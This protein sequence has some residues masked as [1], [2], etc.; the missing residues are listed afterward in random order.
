LAKLVRGLLILTAFLPLPAADWPHWRGPQRNDTSTEES[1]WK[2]GM[3]WLPRDVA[4]SVNVGEGSTSPVVVQGRL[5]TLGWRD[6][7]D[8]VVCLDA[9]TGKRQWRVSYKAPR[10]G[11][12]ATGDEGLYSGVTA[13]P[14]YDASTGL[15]YTLGVDGDL[16]CWDTARSG[17]RVWSLNLYEKYGVRQRPRI[18]R[19]GL[20]DY[21]YTTA[22][23]IQ[24]DLLIVEVGADEG[25]LMAF[26]KRSGQ[27][28]WVSQSK[29]QAGHTG[30]PVPM[31]VEGKPC[32]AVLTLRHLLVV[33]IDGEQAGRTVAEYAWETEFANSIATPAVHEDHVLITSA[34]NHESI[35]KLKITLQG[36]K[37]VWEAPY[38]SGVCT[39]VVHR[40]H[41]YWAFQKLR[42]L[43]LATGRQLWEGGSFGDAGSCILTADERLI[44]WGK[45]GK[46]VLAE[47]AGRSRGKYVELAV[48]DSLSSTDVWPHVVLAD[49]RLFCKDRLGQLACFRISR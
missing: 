41:I 39:P 20:R 14:E 37:K 46:L 30:G 44:V 24:G 4:W 40:G 31:T 38:A 5:F 2:P 43:D 11:R 49:G 48:R 17:A 13:T 9:T 6:G 23:L 10:Y 19:S 1:G 34:Y 26:D 21:G 16:H 15:L 32:V 47:T 29:D 12:H 7:Q 8:H 27:R 3:P 36:A 25:N 35:C 22:P 33:R 45:Q 42:C 28:R 18:G